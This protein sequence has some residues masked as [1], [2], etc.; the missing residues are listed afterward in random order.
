MNIEWATLCKAAENTADGFNIQG[1]N[2]EFAVVPELPARMTA[3]LAVKV[4]GINDFPVFEELTVRIHS[5][6]GKLIL[7]FSG[8]MS[9][10][11]PSGVPHPTGIELHHGF[12]A[13]LSWPVEEYG[14]YSIQA[15]SGD[16]SSY[17]VAFN[18]IDGF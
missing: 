5:P 4:G 11:M 13:L 7:D 15:L 1:A 2:L 9:V 3:T 12:A 8:D 10:E 14:T 6:S 16:G 17:T 18:V